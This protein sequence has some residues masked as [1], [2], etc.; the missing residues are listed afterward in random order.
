MPAKGISQEE[1]QKNVQILLELQRELL[2]HLGE[3]S[4]NQEK[5]HFF[6]LV[7][8]LEF[9]RE[10]WNAQKNQLPS[11]ISQIQTQNKLIQKII[12]CIR[13]SQ[14]EYYSMS[15]KSQTALLSVDQPFIQI[16]SDLRNSNTET[17]Q[18][19]ESKQPFDTIR[20]TRL[21]EIN[22]F[23][24]IIKAQ[25]QTRTAI[26]RGLQAKLKTTAAQAA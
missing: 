20:N 24:I 19:T 18:K 8:Y 15:G 2:L 17:L 23:I 12:I 4:T 10:L 22:E 1:Y 13:K 25:I 26:T 16:L 14:G 3:T 11:I 7:N 5:T 21:P 6:G 9:E